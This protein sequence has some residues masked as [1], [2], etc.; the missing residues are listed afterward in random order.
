[1][2]ERE[3]GLD[4]ELIEGV[5][6]SAPG[7]DA[8]AEASDIVFFLA[9]SSTPLSSDRDGVG[10]ITRSLTPV[11]AVLESIKR[12]GGRRIVIASSGGT[13]YGVA[14][15]LPTPESAPERPISL[16]GVNSLAIEQYAGFYAREHGL[17][18]VILRYSNVFGPGERAH[19]HQGVVA[20]W[21]DAL[22]RGAPL[23]VIGD[24]S[25]RRDF[26]FVE[27]AAAA[28]VLTAFAGPGPA[29]Y[30]VGSGQSHSLN[31]VLDLLRTT[32]SLTPRIQRLS[33]RA[34]DVPITQLDSSRLRA[35]TGWS[36]STPFAEGLSASWSWA[37]SQH[38]GADGLVGT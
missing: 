32:S 11:L 21:C 36:A 27:D 30:N 9:G 14:D 29:T 23:K 24:G 33:A 16:H 25:V 31:D 38:P 28:T 22:C 15:E 18:P 26:L 12:V 34:I 6:P 1:V 35:E 20:T 2:Q 4:V 3:R 8:L 5:L 37:R 7:L 13:V 19:V 17:E 10:S